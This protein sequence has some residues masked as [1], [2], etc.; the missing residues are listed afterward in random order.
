M[1]LKV[2]LIGLGD[3]WNTRHRAALKALSDRFEVRA[4]CCEIAHKA[5]KVAREFGAVA[6]DGFRAMISRNDVEA[7]M[8][9]APDWVGPLPILAACEAGKAVYSS[10]AFDIAPEQINE[11]RD[12]VTQ[13]G[14]AFMAELPRRHAPATFRLKELMATRLGRPTQLF[15]HERLASEEQVSQRRRGKYCPLNWRR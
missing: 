3:H 15:C 9:L 5:E 2:G 10:V 12:R 13:S 8:I 6:L 14:V 1:K 4:V 7:V 11:I